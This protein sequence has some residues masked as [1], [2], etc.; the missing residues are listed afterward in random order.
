MHQA[1]DEDNEFLD[2]QVSCCRTLIVALPYRL[3]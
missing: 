1:G 2:E 3:S